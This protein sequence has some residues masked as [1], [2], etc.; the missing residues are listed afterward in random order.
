MV[1]GGVVFIGMEV[2]LGNQTA[3]CV[4]INRNTIRWISHLLISKR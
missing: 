2:L 3:R 4:S 1:T